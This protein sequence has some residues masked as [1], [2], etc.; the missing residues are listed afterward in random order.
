[1]AP[2]SAYAIIDF[3]ITTNKIHTLRENN[4]IFVIVEI[5][6]CNSQ[7]L[8]LCLTVHNCEQVT[9]YVDSGYTLLL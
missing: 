4:I 8:P 3:I 5:Y 1:M 7:R 6:L 9:Q 2:I